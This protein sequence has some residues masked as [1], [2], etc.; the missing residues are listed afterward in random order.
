MA[1]TTDKPNTRFTSTQRRDPSKELYD[2][3][4]D[5]RAAAAEL[6]AAAGR[7]NNDAAVASTLRCLESALEQAA[8]ATD[9]LREGSVQR[10]HSAWPVLGDDASTT[11]GRL[12]DDFVA[13][14]DAIRAASQACGELRSAVGPL[15]AELTA[16]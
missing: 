7:R 5:V 16:L 6:R 3:A 15:L 13:T 4:C 14:G 9:L 8:V 10:I 12:S 11:A 1:L 2:R